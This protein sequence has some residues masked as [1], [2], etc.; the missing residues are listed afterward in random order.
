M[1]LPPVSP[2]GGCAFEVH[3]SRPEEAQRPFQVLVGLGGDHAQ[4]EGSLRVDLQVLEE[5]GHRW[6]SG[7]KASSAATYYWTLGS[8]QR[9]CQVP[10]GATEGDADCGAV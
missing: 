7:R 4:L 9:L 5:Q 10:I 3:G 1:L 8:S 2:H 6:G